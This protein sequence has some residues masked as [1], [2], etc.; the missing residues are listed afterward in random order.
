MS[1]QRKSL[2]HRYQPYIWRALFYTKRLSGG[3]WSFRTIQKYRRRLIEKG[4]GEEC[5]GLSGKRCRHDRGYYPPSGL[6]TCVGEA[7]APTMRTPA[8]FFF[9]HAQYQFFGLLLD[10]GS[11][12]VRSIETL[13]SPSTRSEQSASPW[14]FWPRKIRTPRCFF[15]RG[16]SNI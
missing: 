2:F 1:S 16:S 8:W 15:N 14:C 11:I 12:V 5:R 9:R 10:F 6:T 3:C 4:S 7:R 13:T